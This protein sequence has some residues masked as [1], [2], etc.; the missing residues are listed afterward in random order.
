[1]KPK[2]TNETLVRLSTTAL[3]ALAAKYQ[4]E[5]GEILLFEGFSAWRF[6]R[7][8]QRSFCLNNNARR[9]GYVS[10]K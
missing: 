9:K 2:L 4:R 3:R 6:G 5:G 7:S 1:M 10:L 8:L